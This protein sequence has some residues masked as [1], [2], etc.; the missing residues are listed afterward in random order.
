MNCEWCGCLLPDKWHP[1]CRQCGA[2]R[3]EPP[4]FDQ[5]RFPDSLEDFFPDASGTELKPHEESGAWVAA[6][7]DIAIVH[8][9]AHADCRC[10]VEPVGTWEI[11]SAFPNYRMD[12]D[13][14]AE[15]L[16]PSGVYDKMMGELGGRDGT[17][18]LEI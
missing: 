1:N 10:W 12:W 14:V 16:R 5:I 17:R 18:D 4:R 2:P 7:G 13:E 15:E 11:Q 9:Y 6:K 8:D 3:K